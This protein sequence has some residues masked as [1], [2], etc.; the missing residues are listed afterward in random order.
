MRGKDEIFASQMNE[1]KAR[2]NKAHCPK[3]VIQTAA[4]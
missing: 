3:N 4:R 1:P 2:Y